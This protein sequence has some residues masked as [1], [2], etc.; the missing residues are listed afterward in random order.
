MLVPANALVLLN[1]WIA[2]NPKSIK[3]LVATSQPKH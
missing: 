1:F 3:R 2:D